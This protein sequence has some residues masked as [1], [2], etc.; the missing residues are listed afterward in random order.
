VLAEIAAVG[1]EDVLALSREFFDPERQ[2]V[3]RLGPEQ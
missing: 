1:R 3:V 2:L